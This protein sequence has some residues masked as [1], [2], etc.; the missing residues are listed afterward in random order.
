[1][2]SIVKRIN[3]FIRRWLFVLSRIGSVT[4]LVTDPK[5]AHSYYPEEPRKS[6]ARIWLELMRWL[7]KHADVN[8]FYYAYGFDLKK[9][10][11]QDEYIAYN[12][13]KVLRNSRND[14]HWL[15]AYCTSYI[16]L[17]KDKYAFYLLLSS[18]GYPTPKVLGVC[19]GHRIDWLDTRTTEPADSIL[20]RTG[21]RAFCKTLLGESAE[22]AFPCRVDKEQLLLDGAP[23]TP[24][25]LASREEEIG[26]AHV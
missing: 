13:F 1:M 16:C 11:N 24:G 7:V 15:G 8:T 18:L 22:G 17:L 23:V 4:R 2:M 26:R 20:R 10:V 19:I 9:D 21:L 14:V 12:E 25:E 3:R 6:K 5:L